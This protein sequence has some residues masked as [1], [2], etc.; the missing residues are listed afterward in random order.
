[1]P[2]YPKF[3]YVN[4]DPLFQGM[5]QAIKKTSEANNYNFTEED[6]LNVC[7]KLWHD[8]DFSKYPVRYAT[9]YFNE[10]IK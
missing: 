1:M 8:F 4:D 2:S 3:P 7:H 5:L 9:D 10:N 6:C